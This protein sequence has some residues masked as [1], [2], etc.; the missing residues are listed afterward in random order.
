VSRRGGSTSRRTP[1][2]WCVDGTHPVRGR[3]AEGDERARLWAK[4]REVDPDLDA[5]AALRSSETALV[6]LER[7]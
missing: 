3:A 5:Y 7:G 4:W 2:P 1:T 6:V